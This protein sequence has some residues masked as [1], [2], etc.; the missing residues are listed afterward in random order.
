MSRLAVCINH[1]IIIQRNA[2][3]HSDLSGPGFARDMPLIATHFR[4]SCCAAGAREFLLAAVRSGL[5]ERQYKATLENFA[6]TT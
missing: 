1:A 2:I 5:A 4:V 6:T 3:S